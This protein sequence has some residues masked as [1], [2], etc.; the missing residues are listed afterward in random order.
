MS[1]PWADT[2]H[3]YQLC[4][5]AN[6]CRDMPLAYRGLYICQSTTCQ[7]HV[8]TFFRCFFV[9]CQFRHTL[10]FVCHSGYVP[11]ARPYSWA[12][13][14]LWVGLM[15]IDYPGFAILRAEGTSLQLGEAAV[16]WVIG[17]VGG[18]RLRFWLLRGLRRRRCRP[19]RLRAGVLRF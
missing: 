8:P 10:A 18:R 9:I 5:N 19:R 1:E 14:P 6:D 16:V 4:G 11:K 17:F 15:G 2:C 13:R 3:N 12:R 7:R